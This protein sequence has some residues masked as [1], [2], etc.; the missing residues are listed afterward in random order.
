MRD[1]LEERFG[2]RQLPTLVLLNGTSGLP[3]SNGTSVSWCPAVSEWAAKCEVAP[4][5]AD[6]RAAFAALLEAAFNA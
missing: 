5:V 6:E 4:S 1:A 2:I 3:I